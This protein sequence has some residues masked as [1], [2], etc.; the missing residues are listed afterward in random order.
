MAEVT[1]A[2]SSCFT[3]MVITSSTRF[4]SQDP[5]KPSSVVTVAQNHRVHVQ[6]DQPGQ[7]GAAARIDDSG[8]GRNR[9]LAHAPFGDDPVP[10]DQHHRM[11]WGGHF[12]TVEE[13]AADERELRRCPLGRNRRF[14]NGERDRDD[15]GQEQLPHQEPPDPS[16]GGATIVRPLVITNTG[17]VMA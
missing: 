12:I 3:E 7:H 2:M 8:I 4:C 11:M 16:V 5:G 14:A 13:H 9:H 17:D 10:L 6:V 1:P 15:K